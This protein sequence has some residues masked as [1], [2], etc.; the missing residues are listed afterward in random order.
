M[1]GQRS[2]LVPMLAH[3]LMRKMQ[4]Q[5]DVVGRKSI[6]QKAKNFSVQGYE[7]SGQ[8]FHDVIRADATQNGINAGRA[9]I[10]LA[11]RVRVIAEVVASRRVVQRIGGVSMPEKVKEME[12]AVLH[13]P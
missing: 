11:T 12:A 9:L 4:P 8:Q 1:K 7:A 5:R 10:H 6:R 2:N 13:I 3:G